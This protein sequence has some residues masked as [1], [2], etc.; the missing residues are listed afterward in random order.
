MLERAIGERGRWPAINLLRS[1]SRSMPGC[2]TEAQN[3]LLRRV[4]GIMATY[5]DMAELIRLGAYRTGSD[6]KVDEAVKFNPGI[7]AFLNQGKHEHAGM[8]TVYAELAKAVNEP[9]TEE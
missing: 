3:R 8:G 1:V 7:D 5:E 4:R 2:N 6:P 9:W